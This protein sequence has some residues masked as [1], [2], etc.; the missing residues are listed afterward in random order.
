MTK[1]LQ[2]SAEETNGML[3]AMLIAKFT[4]HTGHRGVKEKSY[5]PSVLLFKFLI[6]NMLAT[7]MHLHCNLL[8]CLK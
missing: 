3:T 1:S 6:R 7:G 2:T 8:K 5:W 4:F